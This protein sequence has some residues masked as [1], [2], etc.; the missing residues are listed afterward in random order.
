[1]L[2]YVFAGIVLVGLVLVIVGMCIAVVT[3]SVMGVSLSY[4][5]FADEWELMSAAGISNTFA[6]VAFIVA[7]V[8][9][10]VLAVDAILRVF[11]KKDI[12]VL[13]IVGVAL[14]FVGAVLILVAGLLLAG[15][16]N[17]KSGADVWGAGAGVWLG[18]IGGLVATVGGAL[19]LLKA[20]N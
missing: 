2:G 15:D 18:F 19:P 17:D 14:A 9:A 5:L 4:T 8:G 10:V 16:M 12:K 6:L 1:M 13:R 7:I 3:A 11:V 20:F